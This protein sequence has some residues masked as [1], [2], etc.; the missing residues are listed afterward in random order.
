MAYDA[1][2]SQCDPSYTLAGGYAN[3]TATTEQ[4]VIAG[5]LAA[6]YT[7]VVPDYEGEDLQWTIGRQ[8]GYA[9]LDGIRAAE[10]FLRL[11]RSTPV[12]LVGYSGGSIPTQWGAEVAP[13]Y[14][15]ELNIIGAAAGGL[16][17][18]LAHNLPYI[19]GSAKWAGVIPALIVAYQRAYRLDTSA[20]LSERGTQ[21]TK[22]VSSEC[23]SQF[24]SKY[25]GLTSAA[26]VAPPYTGLLDVPAVVRAIN[27]NIMGS[28][29]TPRTKMFLAVGHYN[30]IGDTLMITGDVI[31]L[32]HEYCSRGVD[33][34]Y[35]QLNGLTHQEA[36]LPFE[37]LAAEYL[38][39][40][41]TGIPTRSN[42]ASLPRGN[43]LAPLPIP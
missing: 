23:I 37:P 27:D 6:G 12:G 2:G 1:L 28:Q 30:A 21:V 16:P 31:G 4:G 39:E 8:S 26:M 10:A 38:T 5:Y 20:F 13:R 42:C 41:F 36:F 15:P 33:V 34:T 3:G 19:D 18:D 24:A 17:V 7:V 14:A 35:Q 40:R 11:P 32:A 29:G 25:P 43:S 9:A 22:A